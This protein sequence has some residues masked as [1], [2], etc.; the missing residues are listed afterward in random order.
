MIEEELSQHII[1]GIIKFQTSWNTH[2]PLQQLLESPY[3]Y[4]QKN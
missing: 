1:K 2:Q 3:H 4:L